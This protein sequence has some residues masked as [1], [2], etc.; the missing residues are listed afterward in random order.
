VPRTVRPSEL[1]RVCARLPRLQPG[2]NSS[3]RVAKLSDV[4]NDLSW[5]VA[6]VRRGGSV[7]ILVRGVPVA[8][9]VP[10]VSGAEQGADDAE[11]AEL[12]KLGLARRGS[13]LDARTERE[14]EQPGPRVKQGSR[15]VRW[16]PYSPS[17]AG[18]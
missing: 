3:M 10:I 9:L 2:Y 7:R 18:R 6:Q 8:D 1:R 14:L 11:L 16:K 17:G 5:Y 12:E 4:K 13:A 15:G